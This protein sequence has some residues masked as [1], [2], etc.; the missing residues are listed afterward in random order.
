MGENLR[1]GFVL[2]AK[3]QGVQSLPP[4]LVPE[5]LTGNA[6]LNNPDLVQYMEEIVQMGSVDAA[7]AG[8]TAH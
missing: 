2:Q 1:S 8:G 7:I 6:R 4:L 3:A 5:G